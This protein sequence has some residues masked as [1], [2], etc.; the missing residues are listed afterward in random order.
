MLYY[1]PVNKGR[2]KRS[3]EGRKKLIGIKEIKLL[4]VVS[5]GAET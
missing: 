5:G 2:K 3:K 4:A 1:N